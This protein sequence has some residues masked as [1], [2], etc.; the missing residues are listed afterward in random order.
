MNTSAITL[1]AIGSEKI[2]LGCLL[3]S[4]EWINPVKATGLQASDFSCSDHARIY[5]GLTS[6]NHLQ[7]PIDP[8]GLSEYLGDN[9][10]DF[11]VM[12][13]LLYGTVVEKSH[14]IHHA[15]ILK[16]KARLRALIHIGEWLTTAAAEPGADPLLVIDQ[17]LG[18]LQDV[19]VIQ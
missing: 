15:Q 8:V 6:L 9:P 2:V 14:C 17:A 12:L 7:I 5:D 3:E 18:K 19:G 10:K 4:P 13:D 1:V 16:K 11:D